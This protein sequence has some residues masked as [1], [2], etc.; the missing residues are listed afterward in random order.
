MLDN[1]GNI[2]AKRLSSLVNYYGYSLNG[3]AKHLGYE[4]GA[5]VANAASGRNMPN[6]KLLMD[7]A[8]CF[9]DLNFNWLIKGTG[10]MIIDDKLISQEAV[11]AEPKQEYRPLNTLEEETLR[12]KLIECQAKQI[13]LHEEIKALYEQKLAKADD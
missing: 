6:V 7:V 3:F 11:L 1:E 12:A 9:D 13:A 8:R 5:T 10:K 4:R 2:F